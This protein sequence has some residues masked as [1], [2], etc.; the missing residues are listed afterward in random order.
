MTGQATAAARLEALDFDP[1]LGCEGCGAH[2][3]WVI[4]AACCGRVYLACEEC[5]A[6]EIRRLMVL[7]VLD[8][9]VAC[10]AC[11]AHWS[12]NRLTWEPLR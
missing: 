11:S 8:I 1:E 10:A 5:R 7:L 12:R 3:V 2:A 9:C 6:R 4:R